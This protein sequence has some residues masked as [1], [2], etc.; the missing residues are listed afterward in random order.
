[1]SEYTL[2]QG[3]CLEFMKTLPSGSVDCVF[4]DLPY[5]GV[6]DEE[7]DNQWKDREDFINWVVSLAHEWKR[8]TKDNSSVFIFCDEKMEAYIQV[9]L[10]KIF[11]LLNKIVWYKKNSLA[12]SATETFRSFAPVTERALFY[13]TQYD[14]TGWETVKLETLS[15][16][17][18]R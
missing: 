11:L 10:D 1:M 8:I 17:H 6:V 14:P 12:K 7:W 5:F 18:F 9:R 3:D 4:V 16:C 13:T 2:F 15:S